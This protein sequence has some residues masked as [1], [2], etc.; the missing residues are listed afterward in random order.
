M[1][2]VLLV[3]VLGDPLEDRSYRADRDNNPQLN[4]DRTAYYHE[5]ARLSTYGGWPIDQVNPGDMAAAGFYYTK[6]EDVVTCPF[7]KLSM[8]RWSAEDDPAADHR[9]Y[10][11]DC[12]MIGNVPISRG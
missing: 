5:E 4:N 6:Y 7:C 9:K 10:S 1:N 12:R 8:N 2:S 11:P 3:T